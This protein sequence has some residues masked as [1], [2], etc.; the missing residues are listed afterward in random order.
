MQPKGGGTMSGDRSTRP[1]DYIRNHYKII[2]CSVTD[3]RECL[4]YRKC[5]TR[6]MCVPNITLQLKGIVPQGYCGTASAARIGQY[7]HEEAQK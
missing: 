5:K 3:R 2:V 7:A 4:L 1:Q 6:F